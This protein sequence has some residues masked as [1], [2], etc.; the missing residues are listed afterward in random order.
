MLKKMEDHTKRSWAGLQWGMVGHNI[1][2]RTSSLPN[3]CV[4]VTKSRLK[5]LELGNQEMNSSICTLNADLAEAKKVL[6]NNQPL[7]SLGAQLSELKSI[8]K[9]TSSLAADIFY[10]M[11]QEMT[12]KSSPEA[13]SLGDGL[14]VGGLLASL[15]INNNKIISGI[16]NCIP[17]PSNLR[18]V[19]KK[20]YEAT[21]MRITGFVYY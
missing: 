9:R 20:A 6:A 12:P 7:V 1:E 19:A 17:S 4:P 13:I 16:P 5:S 2:K 11:S 18:Y 3:N 14:I 21:L 15:G 10:D 8:N